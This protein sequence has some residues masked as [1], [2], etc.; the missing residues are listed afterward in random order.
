MFDSFIRI[1]IRF[2]WFYSYKNNH[3]MFYCFLHKF[4]DFFVRKGTL[5][6]RKT[7]PVILIIDS[8][9]MNIYRVS[10]KPINTLKMHKNLKNS[11]IWIRFEEKWFSW[12][13]IFFRLRKKIVTFS[14]DRWRCTEIST[15]YLWKQNLFKDSTCLQLYYHFRGKT[16]SNSNMWR[17]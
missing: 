7:A 12:R 8:F 11:C 10:H 5:L 14:Y 2:I 3:K 13:R 4:F 17:V 1:F 6:P 15:R 9:P 16:T